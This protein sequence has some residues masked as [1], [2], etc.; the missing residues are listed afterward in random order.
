M[1]LQQKSERIIYPLTVRGH[2]IGYKNNKSTDNSWILFYSQVE[3]P[4]NSCSELWHLHHSVS[5]SLDSE[6]HYAETHKKR[7]SPLRPV[8]TLE[9]TTRLTQEPLMEGGSRLKPLSPRLTLLTI[10]DSAA[11]ILPQFRYDCFRVVLARTLT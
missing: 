6:H 3:G 2:D 9:L 10:R 4:Q 1:W 11:P 5:L 7:T 8:F